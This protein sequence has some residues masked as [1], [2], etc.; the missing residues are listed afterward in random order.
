MLDKSLIRKDFSKYAFFYD[1]YASAQRRCARDLINS[2]DC[3]GVK[4]ILELGCGTGNYTGLL[5]EKFPYAVIKAV[6][7]S[8]AMIEAARGKQ[9]LNSD[10]F[11]VADAEKIDFADCFDLISSNAALQ[12][13]LD[14]EGVLRRYKRFLRGNGLLIFTI[15][16]PRTFWELNECLG[17]LSDGKLRC[18]SAGFPMREKI[19]KILRAAYSAVKVTAKTYTERFNLVRELITRIKYTGARGGAAAGRGL[20]TGA[21]IAAL[22]AIYKERFKSVQATYEVFFCEG[23]K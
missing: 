17:E 18:V 23:R 15:F 11:I 6:D 21:R 9:I 2:I 4:R 16:G 1:K 7:I 19:E 12:W 20:W 5:R 22:D 13:Y 14:L 10:D 3:A 8:P